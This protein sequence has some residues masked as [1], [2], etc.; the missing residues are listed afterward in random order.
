MKYFFLALIL[1]ATTNADAYLIIKTPFKRR[2]IFTSS[3]SWTVPAGVKKISVHVWGAGGGAGGC[4]YGSTGSN[5]NTGGASSVTGLLS[6]PGGGGGYGA[7]AQYCNGSSGGPGGSCTSTNDYECM[8][9]ATG[10]YKLWTGPGCDHTEMGGGLPTNALSS[11]WGI[12]LSGAGQGGNASAQYYNAVYGGGGSGAYVTG[13]FEVTA[14][15]S[16]TVTVGTGGTA[17]ADTSGG[18]CPGRQNGS[19]GKIVIFY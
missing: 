16:L 17:G 12:S 13:V 14:G 1:I 2:I 8:S 6:A 9:G 19:N 18:Y 7:N 3:T 4:A 11:P 15:S 10:A 5:G